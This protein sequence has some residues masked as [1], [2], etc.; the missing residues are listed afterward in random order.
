MD[1]EKIISGLFA[2]VSSVGAG[3]IANDLSD[4]CRDIIET[5]LFRKFVIFAIAYNTTK[6]IYASLIV[7]ALYLFITKAL[8]ADSPYLKEKSEAGCKTVGTCDK[9]V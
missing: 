7:L 2:L 4:N 1:N 5:R 8:L 6:D 9:I 3:Q